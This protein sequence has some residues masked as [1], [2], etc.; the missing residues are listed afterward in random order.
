MILM[1]VVIKKK[2]I[3]SATQ[4]YILDEDVYLSHSTNTFAKGY[5]SNYSPSSYG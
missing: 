1:V 2:K 4:V 3:D 5:I